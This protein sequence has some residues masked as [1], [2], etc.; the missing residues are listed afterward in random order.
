MTRVLLPDPFIITQTAVVRGLAAAGHGCTVAWPYGRLKSAFKSRY[1][2][3]VLPITRLDRSADA[4]AMD[5]LSLCDSGNFD[6]VLPV[7][8]ESTAALLAVRAA[9]EERTATLLPEEPAFTAGSDKRRTAEFCKSIGIPFP[10]TRLIDSRTDPE[11]L[12]RELLFPVIVKH[13]GNLGGSRGVR[14]AGNANELSRAVEELFARAPEPD[15]LLLQEY[16]PGHLFDVVTVAK[17]GR[18]PGFFCSARKLMYPIS[19]GVTCVAVSAHAKPAIDFAQRIV[20]SLEWN[21]PVEIEFKYDE[22]DGVFKLIEINPRFWGS[23]ETSLRCGVN[24]P[25]IAVDL[26]RDGRT[27]RT[28]RFDAGIRH[29]F[30]IGRVPYAYWQML[31]L[32]GMR[33][34]RDPQIYLKTVFDLHPTDPMPDLFRLMLVARDLLIGKLPRKLTSGAE[35][36]VIGLDRPVPFT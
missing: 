36:M 20:E 26:A 29:K 11:G 28:V 8:T 16:V 35:Q 15:A 7:T 6:V 9:L 2:S 17:N 4:Y 32:Q 10:E 18:T 3:R 34:L 1:I 19:G 31:R 5:I 30:L 25:A 22:R 24:F 14:F 23:L 33:G 12:S 27:S 21:G 13:P